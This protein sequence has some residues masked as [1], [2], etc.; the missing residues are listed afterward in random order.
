MLSFV[1]VGFHFVCWILFR[2]GASNK[3]VILLRS[4]IHRELS[5]FLSLRDLIYHLICMYFFCGS[6][7]R[8]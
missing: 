2:S 3:K 7:A 8:N 5:I 1:I 4:S 6:I